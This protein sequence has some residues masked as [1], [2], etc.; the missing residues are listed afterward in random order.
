MT[1]DPNLAMG[2]ESRAIIKRL[3]QNARGAM[4]DFTSAIKIDPRFTGALCRRAMLEIEFNDFKAARADAQALFE[5]V[6]RSFRT[7]GMPH[8]Y[9]HSANSPMV[10][11]VRG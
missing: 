5:G 2:F 7:G 10:T 4:E 9:L 11:P 1:L 8:S 3:L 6:R